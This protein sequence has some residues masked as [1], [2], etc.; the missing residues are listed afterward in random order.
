MSDA[1][2]PSQALDEAIEGLIRLAEEEN[3]PFPD[4][5][6]HAALIQ[7]FNYM[8]SGDSTKNVV[9]IQTLLLLKNYWTALEDGKDAMSA[10]TEN[11]IAVP[12]DG[13][14]S[15]S[16]DQATTLPEDN[17]GVEFQPAGPPP[18][19]N[20]PEDQSDH[21]EGPAPDV[22]SEESSQDEVAN[23]VD[24]LAVTPSA[25]AEAEIDNDAIASPPTDQATEQTGGAEPAATLSNAGGPVPDAVVGITPGIAPQVQPLSARKVHIHLKNARVGEAYEGQLEVIGFKQVKLHSDG[26]AGI[27]WDDATSTIT[28]NF[29]QAGDFKLTFHGLCDGFPTE[30]VASLAVIPDP[31]SLWVSKSSDREDEYWKPDE[32][33][34]KFDGELFCAAASKRGRSHARDGGFRDD[35]FGLK[36]LGQGSWHIATVADGAGSAKFSRRGSKIA[37]D[38]VLALLPDLLEAHVSPNLDMLLNAYRDG[39]GGAEAKIKQALYSS[40]AQAAFSAAKA[41]ESEANAKPCE[42]NAYY[43]TLIIGACKNTPSGWFFASFSIGDGGA[44]VF[45]L[46]EGTIKPMNLPDG[47]EFAGQ[48]RFLQ[49][50]EFAGGYEDIA[51]RLFF[52]IRQDFTAF[53]LMTDGITDPKFPTDVV[54]ADHA[55]WMEFWRED[56]TKEVEFERGNTELEREFLNWMDFWSPGNHDDR[57]LAV[58]IP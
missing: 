9:A 55:K 20:K 10:E 35:D 8:Q 5:T 50:S 17:V 12:S 2:K 18:L 7:W 47:G 48:T 44:A 34:D 38:T 23:V 40:L 42:P 4:A 37:V 36:T 24:A 49:R 28:G 43:T 54:F 57:T 19:I 56:F 32:A 29:Q 33:F 27:V 58:M 51:K 53:L 11:R 13:I 46:P 45:S 39:D 31:K 41:I 3:F 52:D 6:E 1:F 15:I 30:V 21:Y 14:G 25:P 22:F 16:S 26:G